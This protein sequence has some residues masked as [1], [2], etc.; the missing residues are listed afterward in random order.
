VDLPP[1]AALQGG[2][3]TYEQAR[4]CGLSGRRLKRLVRDRVL[5][6]NGY[7]V[8][9]VVGGPSD[10]LVAHANLVREIQLSS[11]LGWYAARRTSAFLME[12]PLIGRPPAVPQLVRDGAQR[13]A[14][15]R[16]RHRR[17]SPLP[18]SDV[19]E[20]Q[21]IAMCTPARTVVD[22]ARA[23]SFRNAVVV[24]DAALR[25]GVEKSDMLAVL[26][27][28]R[29]WPGIVGAREAVRFAD[30]RA[31]SAGESLVR[32][33]G[34]REGLPHLEPQVE[35]YYNGQFLGRV[36]FM[37]EE[38]LL[39]LESDGAVKFTDAGVLPALIGRQ[40]EIRDAGVD[41]LRTNWAETFKDTR[42]FGDRVRQRLRERGR[43]PLPPGLELRR[44]LVRPQLPLL[45]LPDDLAA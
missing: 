32:V 38:Y 39:A 44:T 41:V 29:R 28:M 19:W 4:A 26:R 43:R 5:T 13:G 42:P 34:R 37:I 20:Y 10:P 1:E 14:H 23:E 25:R 18:A 9:A 12:L 16:D 3:F 35:V 2:R 15:G 6:H 45:G 21:G 8:Y 24:A 22:I 17:I 11:R 31:E 40:E 36:D 27:G 30:G 7:G 33:A